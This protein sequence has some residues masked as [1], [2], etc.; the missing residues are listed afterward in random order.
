MNI[1]YAAKAFV[2]GILMVVLLIPLGLINA[3]IK[4]RANYRQEAVAKIAESYAG[5]QLLSGPVLVV[6]YVET[7]R[8]PGLDAFGK[9]V[10]L[11]KRENGR[12]LFF[13]KTFSLQGKVLPAERKLGLHRVR[14][15]EL[16]YG[17]QAN[18]DA[19]LPADPNGVR[20]IGVPYLS[21]SI[22]DGVELFFVPLTDRGDV[23][24]RVGLVNGNELSPEAEPDHRREGTA[25]LRAHARRPPRRRRV[26]AHF[27]AI[28]G[29]GV[30]TDGPQREA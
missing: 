22:A 26:V 2:I 3:T 29:V 30:R 15:Y 28:A 12:W 5:P 27:R 11:I 9:S 17:L 6:P 13:P 7:R 8:E 18:F 19:P 16:R 25:R 23:R 4:D 20:E 21:F 1:R 10:E 24:L 14:V